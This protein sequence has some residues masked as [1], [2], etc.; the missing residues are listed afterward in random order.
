MSD[1]NQIVKVFES[2]GERFP[3]RIVE[4]AGQPAWV[5]RDVCDA[6][7]LTNVSEALSGLDDDEKTT[8]SNPDS[9]PGMGAQSLLVV[10]EPGLY[11]LI[12]RSRKPRAKTFKR[13]VTHEVLPEIRRTGGYHAAP[14]LSAA[15]AAL[16]ALPAQMHQQHQEMMAF[17]TQAFLTQTFR[18]NPVLPRLDSVSMRQLRDALG[19]FAERRGLSKFDAFKVVRREQGVR[20]WATL[21]YEQAQAVRAWMLQTM[22]EQAASEEPV[23]R[24]VPSM[25]ALLDKVLSF[26]PP[27]TTDHAGKPLQGPPEPPFW[28]YPKEAL[29]EIHKRCGINGVAWSLPEGWLEQ[30]IRR[31]GIHGKLWTDGPEGRLAERAIRYLVLRAIEFH[32]PHAGAPVPFAGDPHG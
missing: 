16:A 18:Q 4:V 22:P 21:P 12:L 19:V 14:D 10:F 5:A 1:S 8:I 11:S 28:P 20:S 30:T 26:V 29:A 15:L 31:E 25:D 3:V 32:R 7:G 23:V 2:D 9:R 6:L 17:L 24:A 27:R 13:W